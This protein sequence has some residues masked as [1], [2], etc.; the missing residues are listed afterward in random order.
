MNLGT[1][2]SGWFKGAKIIGVAKNLQERN[3]IAKDKIP[4]RSGPEI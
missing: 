4:Y 3:I 2:L 1:E